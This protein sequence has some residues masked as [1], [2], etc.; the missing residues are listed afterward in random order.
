MQRELLFFVRFLFNHLESEQDGN[1]NTADYVD[2]YEN[3]NDTKNPADNRANYGNPTG[4][5]SGK[6]DKQTCNDSHDNV[7]DK[8]N[9]KGFLIRER[10]KFFQIHGK[11]LLVLFRN[12]LYFFK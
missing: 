11:Y 1:D 9:S 10:K 4:D 7:N 5:E 8:A 3:R 6:T 12:L 2:F